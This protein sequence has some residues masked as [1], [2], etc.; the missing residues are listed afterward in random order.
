MI[1]GKQFPKCGTVILSTRSYFS[2]FLIPPPA[3]KA[4]PT[5]SEQKN[6]MFSS[7]S[8]SITSIFI[9]KKPAIIMWKPS[10]RFLENFKKTACLLTWKSVVFIKKKFSFQAMSYLAKK[11][12]LRKK[13]LTP[14]KPGLNQSGYKTL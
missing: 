4:M 13:E 2:V 1:S 9:P 6:S 12:V 3:Y 14:W 8:N 7:L 5:K 10:S 11:S